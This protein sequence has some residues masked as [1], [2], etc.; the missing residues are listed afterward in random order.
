MHYH[1]F[2]LQDLL[3]GLHLCDVDILYQR[4]SFDYLE[5]NVKASTFL[6]CVH[7]I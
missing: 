1:L 6:H 4:L 7:Y 3:S 2:I 5:Y